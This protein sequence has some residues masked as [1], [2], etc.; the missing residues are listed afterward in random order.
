M[1]KDKSGL[2]TTAA[3]PVSPQAEPEDNEPKH[4][5]VMDINHYNPNMYTNEKIDWLKN[6]HSK[7]LS[8]KEAAD[9]IN[10]AEAYSDGDYG[11]IHKGK[12]PKK[13][14]LIDAMIEDPKAP[15]YGKTTYRGIHVSKSDLGGQDPHKWIEDI[16]A[17]GV[18]KE[19]GVSSFSATKQTAMNFGHFSPYNG[20]KKDEIQILITNHGHTKGMPFK[21]ISVCTSENEVLQSSKTMLAGMVITGYHTNKAGNEYFIEV[22][23][24]IKV[25]KSKKGGSKKK[26]LE[27]L[28]TPKF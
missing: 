13:T 8:S 15:V 9:I 10:A 6:H 11:A 1:A 20:G 4:P 21:H 19:P 26:K 25:S 22:D 23:D 7:Q 5:V 17:G 2:S 16:I 14:E 12:S 28:L 27:A 3:G 18:W 24:S